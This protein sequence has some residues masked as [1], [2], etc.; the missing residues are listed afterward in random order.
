MDTLVELLT[1][2]D[3]SD[4]SDMGEEDVYL[5]TID[6]PAILAVI[7]LSDSILITD[8]GE[9]NYDVIDSLYHDH[10]YFIYPGERDRFGWVTGCITTRKGIIVFG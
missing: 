4:L 9:P 7:A 8:E 6:H 2:L 1:I 3:E 10:G 5:Q